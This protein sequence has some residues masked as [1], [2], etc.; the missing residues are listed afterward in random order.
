LPTGQPLKLEFLDS[1]GAL[2]PHTEP[3]QANLR[4]LGI[5]ATTRLV[6][7]AQY[8]RRLQDFDFDVVSLSL[9]GSPTPGD[10][11]RLFYGSEA[12]DMKGSRNIGGV[13]SAAIDAILDLIAKAQSRDQLDLACRVL[14][15]LLRAG[16]YWVP[17]WYRS[18]NLIAYWD[19]FDR[20][21]Q[22]PHYSTGAPSTWWWD[23]AKAQ[24]ISPQH[25]DP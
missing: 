20:P 13:R 8:V 16:A 5:E 21:A 4:R 12:A 9:S 19:V 23:S 17:M 22:L 15:R 3:F 6:D 18:K 11:L 10:E 14:D 24:R 25:Q 2:Q 7:D 1:N